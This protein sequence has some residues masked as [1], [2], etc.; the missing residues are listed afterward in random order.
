MLNA[1]LRA[2]RVP[3][4]GVPV[5]PGGQAELDDPGDAG[6]RDQ[7]H[8]QDSGQQQRDAERE[9]PVRLFCRMKIS[10]SNSS[11]TAKHATAAHRPLILVRRTLCCGSGTGVPP[12]AMPPGT[13]CGDGGAA[14]GWPGWG[15]A[16]GGW[17]VYGSVAIGCP[18]S[19]SRPMMRG[20]SARSG[21]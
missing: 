10:S 12:A 14:A 5:P 17:E 4:V 11:T 8:A 13:G 6:D 9:V 7:Q 3:G 15:A 16:A 2:G 1:R 18:P 19:G 20:I 21:T